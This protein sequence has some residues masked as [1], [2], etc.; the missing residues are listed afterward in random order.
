MQSKLE[1]GR[2][3]LSHPTAKGEG[4]EKHWKTWLEAYLPN[5]Y[6]VEKAFV[7][8]LKGNQS[9]QI[10][11]V[12]YDN[13]YSPPIF[14]HGGSIFIPAESVYAVFEVKQVMNK[15]N[16]EYAKKKVKSVRILQRT[17]APITHAGGT[18]DPLPPSNII[19]GILTYQN[20]WKPPFGDPFIS[21]MN[22]NDKNENI[23]LGCSICCGGFDIQYKEGSDISFE[24]SSSDFSL[25][26]FFLKL[27]SR[28]QK[29]GTVTAMDI[30][31]Y[32]KTINE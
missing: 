31:E 26:F 10:D 17:S 5:R 11:L 15:A 18:Y 2:E 27:L 29:V 12:I 19:S 7:L 4:S 16:I 13:Q 22:S 30:S 23:N 6:S 9:D 8:D 20:E 24:K 28:L 25:V 32:L 1:I 14:K 21:A 3:S